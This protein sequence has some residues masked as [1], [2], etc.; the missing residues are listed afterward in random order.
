MAQRLGDDAE[1]IRFLHEGF[2]ERTIPDYYVSLWAAYYGEID[3]ALAALRRFP[4]PWALWAPVMSEVRQ[5]PA[6]AEIIETT[7]LPHYWERHGWGDFCERGADRILTC[8]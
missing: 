3:L 4:D 6:F 7:A 2:A 5:S 8:Q 1:A